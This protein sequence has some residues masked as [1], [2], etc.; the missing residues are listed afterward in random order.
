RRAGAS[1]RIARNSRGTRPRPA[2]PWA[3]RAPAGRRASPRRGAAPRP[4]P[5]S[6]LSEIPCHPSEDAA[7][8]RAE[9]CGAA[10]LHVARMKEA[11]PLEGQCQVRRGP[12]DR[13]EV[14]LLI[15]RITGTI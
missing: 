9:L 6:R 13:V 14:E 10:E 2:A 12:P 15:A 3:Q 1:R 5:A 8:D 4:W 7:P 11:A